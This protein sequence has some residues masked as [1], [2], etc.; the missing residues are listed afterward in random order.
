MPNII[1][2]ILT[3]MVSVGVE[4]LHLVGKHPFLDETYVY[5]VNH[6]KYVP[7]GFELG[8]KKANQEF[9]LIKHD[10]KYFL[11]KKEGIEELKT[12]FR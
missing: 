2:A 12:M 10:S 11:T 3:E 4:E 6:S 8:S 1:Y 5:C 9:I 7:K